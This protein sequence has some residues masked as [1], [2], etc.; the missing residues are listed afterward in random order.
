MA[1]GQILQGSEAIGPIA[2]ATDQAD[3]DAAGMGQHGFCVGIDRDGM[4]QGDKILQ[5]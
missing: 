2:F 5:P 4:L 1:A 3:E